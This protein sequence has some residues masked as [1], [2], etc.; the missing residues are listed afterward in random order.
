MQD[1]LSLKPL[2]PHIG[3]EVDG[4]DVSRALDDNT[5]R[6]I[7]EALATHAVLVLRGQKL[8]PAELGAFG[9]RFGV[10]RPHL[11][12]G[13]Q[14]PDFPEVS[15]VTN[16][17]RDGTIDPF[18]V[19][20]ATTWHSD[21]TYKQTIPRLAMLHGLEVPAD[22]GGTLFADMRAAFD[23]LP[24]AMRERLRGMT[25]LHKFTAG[26]ADARRVYA[27]QM[28]DEKLAALKD[29]EHPAVVRHPGNGRDILFVNPSHTHGFVG[30]G[31]DEGTALIE[32]LAEHA[33]ESRFVYHHRWKVGDLVIWDEVS[34]MH[35]G[36]GDSP[37]D[38]RRML[39]RTIVH[40]AT[41]YWR[42]AEH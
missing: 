28:T 37:P 14:H 22:G 33:T 9:R 38:Q 15:L 42:A 34:T 41:P 3:A 39:M 1:T 13:Y 26:P 21:E 10:P 30:L 24:P 7:A 18:G 8:D 32:Q 40:P 17:A 16:V 20:R 36:A 23:A 27:S 25:G 4:L 12:E 35:K 5:V 11:L 29:W 19:K 2:G 6:W 31:R